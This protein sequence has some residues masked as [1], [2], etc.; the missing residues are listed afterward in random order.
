MPQLDITAFLTQLCWGVI[1][2]LTTFFIIYLVVLPNALKTL[3]IRSHLIN[4]LKSQ[5]QD[6]TQKQPLKKQLQE[7]LSDIIIELIKLNDIKVKSQIH[8]HETNKL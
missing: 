1:I 7:D 6:K 4:E 2:L 5:I 8:I 3:R